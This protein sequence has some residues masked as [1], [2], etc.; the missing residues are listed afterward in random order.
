MLSYATG[1]DKAY[2]GKNITD[3]FTLY[4]IGLLSVGRVKGE[5]RDHS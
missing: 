5:V 4:K 2:V 1:I 3:L